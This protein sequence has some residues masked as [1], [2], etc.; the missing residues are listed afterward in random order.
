MAEAASRP[1]EAWKR[2]AAERALGLVRQGMLLGLGSGSTAAYFVEGLGRMV[3]AG[4]RVQAVATSA[5]T[6][7]QARALGIPLLDRLERP[8]DLAVDG[9]DEID[10]ALNC[11]KGRGGALLREKIVAQAARRFVLIADERK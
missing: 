10:P 11:I 8:L 1:E 9:A 4:L 5:A 7:S 2:L 3:A 6:A